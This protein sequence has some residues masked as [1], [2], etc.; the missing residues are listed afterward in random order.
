MF[1]YPLRFPVVTWVASTEIICGCLHWLS[2]ISSFHLTKFRN[3]VVLR[4]YITCT[5]L[6]AVP[7][8]RGWGEEELQATQKEMQYAYAHNTKFSLVLIF[9]SL[10]IKAD[11]LY[12][13]GT[14]LLIVYTK[15]IRIYLITTYQYL[16][17]CSGMCLSKLKEQLKELTYDIFIIKD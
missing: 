9:K 6:L 14:P 12:Y 8:Q 13:I 5:S 3:N 1:S 10:S 4:M 11:T 16:I 7:K 15:M 17:K 2:P